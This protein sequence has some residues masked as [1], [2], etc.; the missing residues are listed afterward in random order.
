MSDTLDT[1]V[2]LILEGRRRQ[3][4]RVNPAT[5]LRPVDRVL[6]AGIRVGRPARLAADQVAFR[7]KLDVSPALFDPASPV[8]TITLPD[9]LGIRGPID[10]VAVEPEEVQS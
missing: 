6:V 9:G 7:V 2:Y 1:T 8:A 10:V 5:G 3:Y 4:G